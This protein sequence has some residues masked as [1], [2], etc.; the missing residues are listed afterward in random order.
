MRQ[1]KDM[2]DIQEMI[3]LHRKR[4]PSRHAGAQLGISP[5]CHLKYR[6]RLLEAGLLEGDPDELPTLEAVQAAIPQ[7]VPAHQSSSAEPFRAHIAS[8]VANG[9]APR[10]IFD[11]LQRLTP[12]E[13]RETLP[14]Y[15][16]V[17]RLVRAIAKTKP[18]RPE[19]VVIPVCTRPGDVAQ[20]DFGYVGMARETG[21][22]R[23]RKAWVFVMILGYSRHLFARVVFDQS[24]ATWLS[25]HAEAFEFFGGV[26]A[27]VVPDN[28]K[29]A[30]VRAAFLAGD[31]PQVQRAYRDCARHYDFTVDPTPPR[32]PEKKGKVERSVAYVKSFLSG[33]ESGT[34]VG[35]MNE[36]LDRWNDDVAC[37]RVHGSTHRVP[38][39]VFWNEEQPMM[40]VLP[41]K[42]FLVTHWK[43]ASVGESFHVH[44]RSQWWSVPWQHIK[45][46][47]WLQGNDSVVRI[48]VDNVLVAEHDGRDHALYVTNPNHRPAIR[49]QFAERSIAAW[50]DRS[51]RLHPD[52]RAW[53]LELPTADGL[54]PLRTFQGIVLFLESLGEARVPGVVARARKFGLTNVDE[55]R[56]IVRNGLDLVDLPEENLIPSMPPT[57]V[58]H[59]TIAALFKAHEDNLHASSN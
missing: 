47:C 25:L 8:G 52:L 33:F 23:L 28:L 1:R 10:V 41:S 32:S 19:D 56:N 18:V 21:T 53:L 11:H 16:A 27:T 55:I 6:R 38:I 37:V 42:P 54:S 40:K 9:L 34:D 30:V 35:V 58:Y 50:L 3:R 14:S 12:P 48:Y 45:E 17:K 51:E 5:N 2:H 15:D 4:V 29:A 49:G 44:W 46:K 13:G 31:A 24:S 43:Q 26:P 7:R 39:E 59:R 36:A 22:G 57:P 20:V